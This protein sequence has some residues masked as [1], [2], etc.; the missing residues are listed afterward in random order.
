MH[1]GKYPGA[2]W[3]AECFVLGL[4]DCG[5]SIWFSFDQTC[6]ILSLLPSNDQKQI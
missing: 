3:L 1:A 4:I 2:E 6:L 5:L